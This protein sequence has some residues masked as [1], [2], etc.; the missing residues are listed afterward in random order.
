MGKSKVFLWNFMD[1]DYKAMES[2]LEDMA[3]KGWLLRKING[4]FATF[5]RIAPKK[6]HFTVNVLEKAGIWSKENSKRSKERQSLLEEAGWRLIDT[7]GHLQFFCSEKEERPLPVH[8]DLDRE[9]QVINSSLWK[10]QLAGTLYI[11]VLLSVFLYFLYPVGLEHLKSNTI[12]VFVMVLP[13]V[14]LA[15]AIHL[16][17]L[18]V[19]RYRMKR[20]VARGEVYDS[21]DYGRARKKGGIVNGLQLLLAAIILTAVVMDFTDGGA[22]AT[23]SIFTMVLIWVIHQ[24]NKTLTREKPD[25]KSQVLLYLALAAGTIA[26]VMMAYIP[27]LGFDDQNRSRLPEDYPRLAETEWEY[28]K[29]LGEKTPHYL[30][31]QSALLPVSYEAYYYFEEGAFSYAYY[32][33]AHQRIAAFIY[34]DILEDPNTSEDFRVTS[35]K[36]MEE[37][38]A[39]EELYRLWKVD[40]IA[41]HENRNILLLLKGDKVLRFRGIPDVS[42]PDFIQG[43]KQIFF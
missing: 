27:S 43:V 16:I 7:R 14:L 36:A 6:V 24:V 1:L 3:E 29:E 18:L 12:L 28:M 26:F 11:L 30:R 5:D 40:R 15:F 8:G 21:P 9:K 10:K 22:I 25:K 38:S 33:G 13:L 4:N 35:R 41:Y 19:W 31:D 20:S 2:Y 39:D 34:E 37:L 23:S 42:D 17:Y 32:Q